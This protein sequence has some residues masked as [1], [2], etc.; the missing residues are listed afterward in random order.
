MANLFEATGNFERAYD[1]FTAKKTYYQ[2]FLETEYGN[3]IFIGNK[4]SFRRTMR[5][6]FIIQIYKIKPDLKI[7]SRVHLPSL[8]E[9]RPP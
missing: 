9:P 3:C 4:M 2:L 6:Y 8:S 7:N 1:P 5:L